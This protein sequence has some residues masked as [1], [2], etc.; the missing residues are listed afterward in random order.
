MTDDQLK[1]RT[2]LQKNRVSITDTQLDLIGGYAD[3]LLSWNKS[4]NL[5]SR[6]DEGNLWSAHILLSIAFL[7]EAHFPRGIAV[8]DLGTG[9]G[10]PGIP[11]SIMKPEVQ[12]TLLDSIGK[13]VDAVADMIGRLGLSN[14]TA[15]RAR[16]EEYGATDA[17]RKRFDAVLARGVADLSVLINWS[18]PLLRDV[19]PA[20]RGIPGGSFDGSYPALLALKGGSLDDEIRRAEKRYPGVAVI[21]KPLRFEG[22]DALEQSGRQFL[23]IYK[24]PKGTMH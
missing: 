19:Q 10:L 15:V 22:M 9:G 6:K 2:I 5:V 24:P 20:V 16:A 3:L 11:L 17:G 21:R 13:K 7:F 18:L 12:F 14:V 4:V 8:L 1:L 23:T